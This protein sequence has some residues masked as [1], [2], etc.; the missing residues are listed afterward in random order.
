MKTVPPLYSALPTPEEMR[1]WDEGALALFG[2]PP[3]LL[4]ENAARAAR[5][6]LQEYRPLA[7]ESRVLIFMGRGNNGGDGV[8]L[9]RLLHDEGHAVLVYLAGEPDGLGGPAGEHAE[10]A[11][12]MGVNFL[13]RDSAEFPVLPLDWRSPDVVVDA[14]TGTGIRGDLRDRELA[15]VRTINTYRAHAFILALDIPSG[16]CGYTGKPRPEAV[17]AHLTVTFE[18]GKPGLFFPE[19]RE[20]TGEITVRRVG[21][22]LALR[23]AIPPSWRLLRPEKGAWAAPS[24]FLH[25]GSA[26]KTLIIGGSEGMA[27]APLLAALGSLRAG[28]GLVH[29]AV[30]A[31]LEPAFRAACPEVLVHP[32]GRGARWEEGDA[33]TLTALIRDVGPGSLVLGPGMGRSAATREITR[34]VLAERDRPP[35]VVDADALYFFR[36]PD[37]RR[38]AP[39]APEPG[40]EGHGGGEPLPLELFTENDA[41]TP[42][43]GEMA[44]MLPCSFFPDPGSAD[45]D[46]EPAGAAPEAVSPL[47]FDPEE[48]AGKTPEKRTL[49]ACIAVLR[50]DRAGAVRAFTRVCRAVLAL[51][52]PGTLIG[53]RGAPATLS[54]IAAPA[55]SVGGSGDVLAG[56]CAA[57]IASGLPALDA[58]CLAVYLHGRAGELLA[59]KAPRGHLARDIADAIPLA[60][61]ELCQV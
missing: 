56:A 53:R 38:G 17:R 57:V 54:P 35:A 15:L 44:R 52:G 39:D 28:A 43:A 1:R 21:I 34:T 33:E 25:K 7:P 47:D 24:P 48:M 10:M 31:A 4:M 6:A 13:P 51:K 42:H 26:G 60:W 59:E 20:Y 3:L 16:L 2:I 23:S 50:E 22:P 45:K 27:G 19:A 40:G 18:A 14:L 46:E 49:H 41:L 12:K 5:A 61:K 29:A 36:L 11:R 37:P 30:P 8:A 9:A 32:I 55:L 58:V